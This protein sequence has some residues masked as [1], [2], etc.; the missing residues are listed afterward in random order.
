[1]RV[2]YRIC[3]FVLY[4]F[5]FILKHAAHQMR[6]YI[7]NLK[8]AVL[9]V[10]FK[11]DEEAIMQTCKT[12]NRLG[13]KKLTHSAIIINN[14]ETVENNPPVAQMTKLAE[15]ITW[16]LISQSTNKDLQPKLIT[17]YDKSGHIDKFS[18]LLYAMLRIRFATLPQYTCKMIQEKSMNQITINC[19]GDLADTRI[20]FIKEETIP[21]V[22]KD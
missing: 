18:D 16:L 9:L 2:I 6:Y 7:N 14:L 19:K 10:V 17:L 12:G 20:N 3:H 15:V 5:L 1:M 8:W 4:A 22:R 21:K 11:L 13:E